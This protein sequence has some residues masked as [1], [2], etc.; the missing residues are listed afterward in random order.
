MH[1]TL[2][3]G[4][5]FLLSLTLACARADHIGF[6]RSMTRALT[7]SGAQVVAADED[8]GALGGIF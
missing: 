1:T 2:K 5:F 3:I 8:A 4:N 6:G 7:S